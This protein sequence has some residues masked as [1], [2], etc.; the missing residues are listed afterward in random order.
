MTKMM[1]E[2]TRKMPRDYSVVNEILYIVISMMPEG[3]F[4]DKGMTWS[5]KIV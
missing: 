5:K 3:K 1:T 2:V 4:D